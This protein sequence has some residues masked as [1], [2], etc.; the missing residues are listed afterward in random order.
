MEMRAL[1]QHL[2]L[3]GALV[4]SLCLLAL[5]GAASAQAHAVPEDLVPE[6]EVVVKL[7]SGAN[8]DAI[9]AQYHTEVKESLPTNESLPASKS[10]PASESLPDGEDVYL[11][12][13]KDNSSPQAKA[14]RMEHDRQKRLVYA[15]PNFTVTPSEGSGRFKA[16]VD[17]DYA[18]AK[19]SSTQY[20][21]TAL[22]LPC[23]HKVSRGRGVK[24][25]VLDTGAQRHHPALEANFKG[26]KRYD[27]VDNDNLPSDRAV[28][29]DEDGD[30]L[31]DELVGHGTH[32][33]GIVD[34]VAPEAKIMPLRVLNTEGYG[35]VFTI[36]KAIV[37]AQSN[38]AEVI[39]LSLGSP[40][41]SELLHEVIEDAIESGVVV[42][43]AAG[44]ES[45]A[46][47]HYPAAGDGILYS[48]DG[49]LAVTSVN[50]EEKKSDF[51]NYG[52][53]VDIAAPGEDTR[54]AFPVSKYA[55]W[56]GTSMATPFVAGQAA[57]IHAVEGS[58][59][60]AGIEKTIH[61]SARRLYVRD[62]LYGKLL[63]AGH[64]DVCA[65]L[66]RL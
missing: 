61:L 50:Q 59:D 23:A 31:T 16:R 58:L 27:F 45:S 57:L 14:W 13:I 43:A 32:V 55:Y 6:P 18:G 40:D 1:T 65:S 63:G 26:V 8:I 66:V 12:E 22:G 9:N 19:P 11:L 20:A 52:K 35:D 60:S 36:A 44:N 53:W 2:A 28:G 54:S 7:K 41:Y 42:A 25:A 29:L 39:N 33:A 30:G 17:E 64:A 49:L 5:L 37:Y 38:G 15:E 34:L 21:A 4:M 48:A 62:P 10:L 3:T 56:S 46:L 47:P 24:V 51:A